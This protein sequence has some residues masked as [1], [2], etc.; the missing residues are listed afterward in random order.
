[1]DEKEIEELKELIRDDTG[2]YSSLAELIGK[3]AASGYSDYIKGLL[4]EELEY[5]QDKRWGEQQ[6]NPAWIRRQFKIA[7]GMGI[8]IASQEEASNQL[9]LVGELIEPVMQDTVNKYSYASREYIR[10]EMTYADQF[11]AWE[12]RKKLKQ[13]IDTPAG[14]DW[15]PAFKD[16]KQ[17]WK[18]LEL[19]TQGEKDSVVSKG[20]GDINIFVVGSAKGGVGKSVS[21]L[22]LFKY[23]SEIRKQKTVLLDFDASGPS[24][25]YFLNVPDVARILSCVPRRINH[26]DAKSAWSYW[27]LLDLQRLAIHRETDDSA[28]ARAAFNSIYYLDESKCQAVVLLP[29]SPT[30]CQEIAAARDDQYARE[31]IIRLFQI[32]FQTISEE[33]FI[34]AIVDMGPGLYGTNGLFMRWLSRNYKSRLIIISSPRIGDLSNSLYESSWIAAEGEFA[35][36]PPILHFINMWREDEEFDDRMSNWA[37]KCVELSVRK[38]IDENNIDCS[39]GSQIYSWRMWTYFYLLG[40]KRFSKRMALEHLFESEQMRHAVSPPHSQEKPFKC[41]DVFR[42]GNPWYD[43]LCNILKNRWFGDR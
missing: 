28:I 5:L 31:G 25:Q 39:S 7:I 21:A 40:V 22:T 35:W 27:T 13:L 24:V 32:F 2:K 41:D 3:C 42:P 14:H 30:F 38:A 34:N 37:D 10:V 11:V 6:K 16:Y 18:L 1:M 9:S 23:L 29:D 20:R 43:K 8:L 33:K 4:K 15:A 36:Q 19:F 12:T 26:T 17:G